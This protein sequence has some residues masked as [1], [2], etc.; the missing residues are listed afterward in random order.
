MLLIDIVSW[1]LALAMVF[2]ILILLFRVTEV[3]LVHKSY[4]TKEC[5]KI[6]WA[7]GTVSDCSA[8]P[9]NY[10]MIWVK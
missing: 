9:K 6:E 4:S 10:E 3:P 1:I 5:V 8:M 7:D 2:A